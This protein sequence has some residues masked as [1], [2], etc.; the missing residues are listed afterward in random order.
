MNFSRSVP[1]R[2]AIGLAIGLTVFVTFCFGAPP[3]LRWNDAAS[4]N[5]WN[6]TVTN[7][8]DSGDQSVAWQ[9]GA[10][11]HFTGSGATIQIGA[12]VSVTNLA[13]TGSGYTLL[14]TGRL[15]VEGSLT[16][17]VATANSIAANL[18]SV[19]GF[20]KTGA[21]SL[22]L[23]A[24]DASLTNPVAVSQGTLALQS[25]AIP[26]ALSVAS[27]GAVSIL[28]TAVSGLMGFY[29]NVTPNSANFATLA[30]MDAHFLTLTPNLAAPSSLA[31]ANFDFGMLLR[32]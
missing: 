22:T 14:G 30:A 29:Y 3:V 27:P 26:G 16:S 19:G 2:R 12:D 15:T 21:G 20:A 6:A 25:V 1:V 24:P 9:P 10:E 32:I 5:T 31:G 8:L 23:S 28:P 11:A 18:L 17:A 13:F 4:T 7:W